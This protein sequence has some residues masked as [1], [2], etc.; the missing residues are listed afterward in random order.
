MVA[1][2]L[3][4]L[5]QD[6]KLLPGA[7]DEQGAPRWLLSDRVRNRYFTL[8]EDAIALVRY[9]QPGVTASELSEQLASQGLDY[10]EEDITAF[11]DFLVANNLVQARTDAAVGYFVG[12]AREARPPWWQW[13]LHNYLFIRIPL[14][15]PDPW[16]RQL[17]AF[18]APLL[19]SRSERL[20]LLA[21]LV[22]VFLVLRQWDAF[23][24]TFMHFFSWQGLLGYGI[25]LVLVKS[26]H[27]LGHAL[28]A[29][30]L[31]C[32]VSSMG[33][34]FL[35]MFPV[36]YTD[37]TDAWQLRSRVDRLRI[38]TAGVRTELYLALIA[39]LLWSLLPDGVVRSACFF[40]ATTSWV[41]SLLINITPFMRFDGY[42]ALSDLMGVE[43]LQP[44]A[45]ALGR[46]QLRRWLW[47]L[48]DPAP[49]P[50]PRQRARWMILYAWGTWIY[51]FFLFIGIALLVY[52]FF[53]KVLG[54]LL[55][56]V[57]IIWFVLMPVAKE[58][59]V[60][61][62]RK[63][64]FSWSWRRRFLLAVPVM[65]LLWLA[66]PLAVDVQAP[67]LLKAQ[68]HQR[69]FAPEA[70]QVS[71]LQ[72]S[73]GQRVVA[74][75]A[76]LEL[77]SPTLEERWQLA[78]QEQALLAVK[79]QRQAASLEEKAAQTAN[80]QRYQQLEERL[81]ALAEQREGLTLLAPFAGQISWLESLQP[82]QWVMA[83]QPLF[84]VTQQ[85]SAQLE[86]FVPERYLELLEPGQQAFFIADHGQLPRL[87]AELTS[88]DLGALHVLPYAELSSLSGG[89]IAVR[90]GAQGL[91]PQDAYYRVRFELLDPAV[92]LS[93]LRLTGELLIKGKSRSWLGL[94]LRR[95]LS[96]L[97]REGGF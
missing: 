48:Q 68:Q 30:R 34:A 55:F 16:L 32:R 78:S 67:G 72:V 90:A 22:G 39:T 73:L 58:M 66:L 41:T 33:V 63:A 57:E 47:G 96:V 14:L 53:F 29:S 3:S 88:I 46:W 26:A 51:R 85:G 50:L 23:V 24:A 65:L 87:P 15:R 52:H 82:G 21:G 64:D 35:V 27:E 12:K 69:V 70:A 17:A 62:E 94:Q 84:S 83:D 18:L 19:T 13:L 74:D 40:V 5:R 86:A 38:V 76:L 10:A 44:R 79:L 60:W 75:Q 8:A 28:V 49:E 45:F 1:V 92:D 56:V 20:V 43:N 97:V 31:G 61:W 54:I 59:R 9:W 7:A 93:S 42:F 91:Q 11:N 36:L 4:A 95:V 81:R 80:R 2:R 37:T 89:P 71:G 25:T 77:T 6:L